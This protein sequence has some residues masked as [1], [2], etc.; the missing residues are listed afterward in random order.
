MVKATEKK[1]GLFIPERN[2]AEPGLIRGP[3]PR[4][5]GKK[6]ALSVWKIPEAEFS[7]WTF[8]RSSRRKRV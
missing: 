1:I 5:I 2:I 4:V 8:G 3:K 6:S 7:R